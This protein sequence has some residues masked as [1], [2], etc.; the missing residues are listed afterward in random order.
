MKCVILSWSAPAISICF[1]LIPACEKNNTYIYIC[2][3]DTAFA[4]SDTIYSY[5]LFY[6]PILCDICSRE[7][8]ISIVLLYNSWA[9]KEITC[10]RRLLKLY[11]FLCIPLL[12]AC[13]MAIESR[14]LF[15]CTCANRIYSSWRESTTLTHVAV[16]FV[17]IYYCLNL[18]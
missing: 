9:Q 6:L 13:Y 7:E 18:L 5:C 3:E 11:F 8:T 15:T 16:L 14:G 4:R 10:S 17:S 2:M 12:F 1:H